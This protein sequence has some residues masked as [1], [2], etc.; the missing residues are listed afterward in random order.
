MSQLDYLNLFDCNRKITWIFFRIQG[1]ILWRKK[2]SLG[3]AIPCLPAQTLRAC[4]TRILRPFFRSL[5]FLV[6]SGYFCI[7]CKLQCQVK[8]YFYWR[9]YFKI[10]S[11][12][13]IDISVLYLLSWKIGNEAFESEVIVLS[14]FR[15]LLL[16]TLLLLLLL[17]GC[18]MWTI[19]AFMLW[20]N[21]KWKKK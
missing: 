21:T 11:I 7:K 15:C 17:T 10:I 18:V 4:C 1:E 13:I 9:K 20:K 3:R 8:K 2:F 6:K 19:R 14:L 12:F 5:I 16:L